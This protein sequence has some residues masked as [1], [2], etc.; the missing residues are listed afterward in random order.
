MIGFKYSPSLEMSFPFLFNQ[1]FVNIAYFY[2]FFGERALLT[3]FIHD[4]NI[5]HIVTLW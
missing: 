2:D 1:T 5:S 4:Q 3:Y